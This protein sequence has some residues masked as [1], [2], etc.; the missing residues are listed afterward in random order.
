MQIQPVQMLCV[1]LYLYFKTQTMYKE[2]LQC[3]K[4]PV[5]LAECV[6]LYVA[7]IVLT[8]LNYLT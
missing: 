7:Y 1:R 5:L 3:K 4:A 2:S 8:L 6:T